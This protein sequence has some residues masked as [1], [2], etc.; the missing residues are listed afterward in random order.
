MKRG[1][2][3]YS[4]GYKALSAETDANRTGTNID[5]RNESDRV[6]DPWANPRNNAIA[7]HP[8]LPRLF[9]PDITTRRATYPEYEEAK[10][11]FT[12]LP[13]TAPTG[14]AVAT[15]PSSNPQCQLQ[16]LQSQCLIS[17]R[18]ENRIRSIPEFPASLP[19]TD[20]CY[21]IKPSPGKGLGMFASRD[22]KQGEVILAERPIVVVPSPITYPWRAQDESRYTATQIQLALN[23]EFE[24]VIES[25]VARSGPQAKEAILGLV[26][27]RPEMGELWGRLQS[28]CFGIDSLYPEPR[29]FYA[30]ALFLPMNNLEQMFLAYQE[31][32]AILVYS[33][34]SRVQIIGITVI[35]DPP[36][37]RLMTVNSFSCRPNTVRNWHNASFSITL[38]AACDIPKDEEIFTSYSDSSL[39]V[40]E[41][42]KHLQESYGFGCTCK[43]CE[44]PGASEK[45]CLE[46][47]KLKQEMEP[48]STRMAKEDMP[49]SA[50]RELVI[51]PGTKSLQLMDEEGLYA[52]PERGDLLFELVNALVLVEQLDEARK[53]AKMLKSLYAVID[54]SKEARS[55][56]EV[57][58]K[59]LLD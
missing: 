56:A 30:S 45:R 16:V 38:R 39:P 10:N 7:T 53:Y 11:I 8:D 15:Q 6:M 50:I 48:A 52:L 26:H 44:D 46:I 19:P 14:K 23:L 24:N 49:P 32:E 22:I 37:D 12:T 2:L 29:M 1:F 4:K 36:R 17:V 40:A 5:T 33:L 55:N 47:F 41:R 34:P 28:N 59:L 57:L 51:E 43:I 54:V 3:N 31:S 25:L 35:H 18:A 9:L 27:C 58:F 21:A 13:P 42:Q 20:H